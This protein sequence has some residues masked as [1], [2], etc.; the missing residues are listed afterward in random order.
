VD[1]LKLLLPEPWRQMPYF[2]KLDGL[3]GV[4]VI[5]IHMCARVS[6]LHLHVFH[7][8]AVAH[9][10]QNWSISLLV[11]NGRVMFVRQAGSEACVC[12][13]RVRSWFDRKLS[14]VDHLLFSRSDLLSVYADMSTCCKARLMLRSSLLACAQ[15]HLALKPCGLSAVEAL[16]FCLHLSHSEL[17]K[18]SLFC[19]ERH[20]WVLPA[21]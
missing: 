20:S 3:V 19:E 2:T 7:L 5:N 10:I 16:H 14:T 12:G 18:A 13:M 21:C 8:A 15:A 4:P 6:P 9:D 17:F 1:P 11:H